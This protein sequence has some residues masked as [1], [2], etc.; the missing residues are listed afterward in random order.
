MSIAAK[1]KQIEHLIEGR[2]PTERAFILI[3]A[4]RDGTLTVKWRAFLPEGDDIFRAMAAVLVRHPR[5]DEILELM[6]IE[7]SET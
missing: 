7:A 5:G 4:A 6:K 3:T 1:I 2:L